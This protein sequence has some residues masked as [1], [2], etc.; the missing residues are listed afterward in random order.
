MN[1]PIRLETLDLEQLEPLRVESIAEGY[2][3]VDSL[4]ERYRN[5]ERDFEAE[6]AFVFGCYDGE[7]LIAVGGM[8]LDPYVPVRAGRVRRVYV[9]AAYRNQGIGRKLVE[10][11][12]KEGAEDLRPLH[13]P[14]GQRECRSVLRKAW[15]STSLSLQTRPIRRER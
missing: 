3:H 13:P 14:R 11:I 8:T 4:V 10:A 6:G 9:L 2:S 1:S 15:V 7:T 12:L 5:G